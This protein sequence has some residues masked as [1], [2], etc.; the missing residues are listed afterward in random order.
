MKV[1]REDITRIVLVDDH[2]LF[3]ESLQRLLNAEVRFEVVGDFASSEEALLALEKGLIFDVALVDHDLSASGPKR[4][5]GLELLRTLS[6]RYPKARLL[7]VTAG[8]T[9]A[10]SRRVVQEL[11]AGLFLKT[12]PIAELLLAIQRTARGEQWVSSAAALSLLSTAQH[13]PQQ[14][15]PIAELSARE[16]DVLRGVLEGLS[17]KEIGHRLDLSESSVKAVLQKLFERIGVRTRSQ[18]VRIAIEAQFAL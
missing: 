10:E 16:Q 8:M 3:R 9:D 12:E 18:L 2:T 4:S 1:E 5:T 14:P 11:R 13:T 15:A 17:N 7:M 6:Q